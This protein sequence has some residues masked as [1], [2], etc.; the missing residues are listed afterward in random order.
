MT[1]NHDAIVQGIQQFLGR[2]YDY[3]PK[4]EFEEKIRV[5]PDGD[6]RTDPQ[7]DLA[8]GDQV[9]HRPHGRARRKVAK[10]L[11]L[12]SEGYTNI[13]PPQ[14]RD[15]IAVDPRAPAIRRAQRSLCGHGRHRPVHV[16]RRSRGVSRRHR[17]GRRPARRSG[18]SPTRTTSRSTRSIRA[19]WPT[20][21]SASTRTSTRRPTAVPAIDDG[22]A[23][24][25][26]DQHRRPRDRQ[27]ERSHARHEADRPRQ[28]RVLP[29]RLQLDVHRRRT[30]SFT[31]SRSR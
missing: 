31:R 8:V 30:A 6:R 4:N 17:D 28:Q 10:A 15:Q 26:G 21:S 24:D 29:A 16:D 27:P 7:S 13:L 11:I 5:L 18:T 20:T 1:R 23:A 2:K 12:V 3:T 14:M 22:H 9:A 25:A 19:V